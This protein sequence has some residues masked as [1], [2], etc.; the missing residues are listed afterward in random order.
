MPV[1][2]AMTADWERQ[3]DTIYQLYVTEERS[4]VNVIALM[5]ERHGFMKTY[6]SRMTFDSKLQSHFFRT[7]KP[8]MRARSRDGTGE[9]I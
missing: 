8:N 7:A 4:L 5:T 1:D 9:R 2:T 6:A 3:R